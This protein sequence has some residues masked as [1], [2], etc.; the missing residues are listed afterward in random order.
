MPLIARAWWHAD[1]DGACD[2]GVRICR[3]EGVDRAGLVAARVRMLPG[4]A[5]PG[6]LDSVASG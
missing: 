3:Y 6:L 4:A 2:L 1:D 5:L